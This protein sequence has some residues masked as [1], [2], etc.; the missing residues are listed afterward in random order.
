MQTLTKLRLVLVDEHPIY[1]IGLRRVLEQ[2]GRF[3]ILAEAERAKTAVKI[4]VEH[5]PDVAILD[6]GL[7]GNTNLEIA[8]LLQARHCK[9]QFVVLAHQADETLFNYAMSLG[10]KG[11]VLKRSSIKEIIDCIF[12]VGSGRAYVSPALTSLLLPGGPG[13]G[14]VG[15]QKSGLRRLTETEKRVLREIA[16]GKSS[17]QIAAQFRISRRTVESHRAHICEKLGLRGINCLLH[18]AIGHRDSLTYLR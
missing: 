2:D 8:T 6:A 15:K 7:P 12:A 3:E 14:I 1:R 5:A 16:L 9:T 13:G 18:F 4:I 10:I 17:R 11:Y